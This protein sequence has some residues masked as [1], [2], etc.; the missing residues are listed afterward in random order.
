MT[1]SLRGYVAGFR[2]KELSQSLE[3]LGLSKRGRKLE[4][5]NRLLT[6]LGDSHPPPGISQPAAEA[7]KRN[8]AERVIMTIW[9]QMHG[10]S[11][12]Q[13]MPQHQHATPELRERI[14]SGAEA[15]SSNSYSTAANAAAHTHMHAP[16]EQL[17][18]NNNQTSCICGRTDVGGITIQCEGEACGVW[19]H[20]QCVGIDPNAT[21]EHYFC[22][23]CRIALADPFWQADSIPLFTP[24][25]LDPVPGRP[26]VI[27]PSGK[28]ETKLADRAFR[29][30]A[31][32]LEPLR[33]NSQTEQLH[34]AC[35]LL[36]DPV[37]NRTHWPR[38]A[39]LKINSMV[40]R[41]YGRN[42]N[43]KL[44]GNAR[45]EPASA[46]HR[47]AVGTNRVQLTCVEDRAF[48]IM[49]YTVR[50]R[51]MEDVK[52]MMAA[53]ESPTAAATRVVN[54]MH[55]R[56]AGDVDGDDDL[57]VSNTVISL[58]DPLSGTR[59]QT[60]ARF[61]GLP[62]IVAFDLDN[63]LTM[64]QRSR[65]WQDPH[66]LKNVTIKQLQLDS[67]L[68]PV[69]NSLKGLP[70]VTEVE[71]NGEGLWRPNGTSMPWRSTITDTGPL[72]MSAIKIKPDPEQAPDS[73]SEEESE[74]EELR[75]AAKAYTAANKQA[76]SQP[77][78]IVLD[79]SSDDEPLPARP[80]PAAHR[81]LTHVSSPHS[82]SSSQQQHSSQVSAGGQ[83][84][85]SAGHQS[86]GALSR[87]TNRPHGGTSRQ[88]PASFQ[89]N[90]SSTAKAS[91]SG[92]LRIKLSTNS[93]RHHHQHQQPS[94]QGTS[95]H[96]MTHGHTHASSLH[97]ADPPVTSS[98]R[99]AA[100]AATM[101]PPSSRQGPGPSNLGTKRK[102]YELDAQY[103]AY[104]QASAQAAGM[105]MSDHMQ[106]A[107]NRS[108]G[109]RIPPYPDTSISYG[110]RGSGSY[111]QRP[112]MPGAE[113]S[114]PPSQPTSAYGHYPVSP[115]YWQQQQ[116]V[117]SPTYAPS[118]RSPAYA[119][120][121][122][123]SPTYAA[124]NGNQQIHQ[125]RDTSR[126]AAPLQSTNPY[127]SEAAQWHAQP[128]A[129]GERQLGWCA[130]DDQMLEA[131]LGTWHRESPEKSN[132]GSNK[133]QQEARLAAWKARADTA[134]QGQ[135]ASQPA[136]DDVI[137]LD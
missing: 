131:L 8:E 137:V 22:Q 25:K 57:L 34:V 9:N 70:D 52:K 39:E 10:R 110:S 90:T 27:R 13:Q 16:A 50:R 18:R 64:A 112:I 94:S 113:S 120:G 123:A 71:V 105:S 7:W 49:A 89:S 43:T 36:D 46:A 96:Q 74:G 114:Q 78:V 54:T 82:H 99:L 42:Q 86:S 32:Q 118:M 30:T 101:R 48:C 1:S 83:S 55:G 76:R 38:Q 136:N 127:G 15:S 72:T 134:T 109:S 12:D 121:I 53:A 91:G 65:K 98:A 51:S 107:A 95:S 87:P 85:G 75:K 130:S 73:D 45:D 80:Q 115:N 69:V 26:V 88:L 60:A 103:G 116:P 102:H 122:P 135:P 29:L 77:E 126:S 24:A 44:G 41:P 23:R 37:S 5:Q 6:Y 128:L 2:I 56:K 19:Q 28:E 125:E 106:Q 61:E 3:Q 133:Q 20:C 4:L 100:A 84:A 21:P 63:F 31:P 93:A 40:Y 47:C 108:S 59:I 92:S 33:R 81:P 119:S 111:S 67:W 14:E 124:S 35:L 62:G 58:K 97:P 66:T 79:D 117:G 68:Q 129:D 132:P 104:S 11:D 17:G